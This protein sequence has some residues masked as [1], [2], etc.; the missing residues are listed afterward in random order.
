MKYVKG[1]DNSITREGLDLAFE[2]GARVQRQERIVCPVCGTG[3][4]H[5]NE[6]PM[7]IP[8]EDTETGKYGHIIIVFETE[9]DCNTDD[10]CWY[11]RWQLHIESGK[12]QSM[13]TVER[14]TNNKEEK[15]TLMMEDLHDALEMRKVK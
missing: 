5:I 12:G 8:A 2:C 10:S 3:G 1:E 14:G 9:C 13:F 15:G 4:T 6:P 7:W 11:S